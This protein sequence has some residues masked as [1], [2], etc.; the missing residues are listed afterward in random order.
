MSLPNKRNGCNV[1]RAIPTRGPATANWPQ[2]K[3]SAGRSFPTAIP[4][5]AHGADAARESDRIEETARD[6]V[7]GETRLAAI[8]P[9]GAL[10]ETQYHSPHKRDVL[11]V[12]WSNA[13]ASGYL[14]EANG[15]HIIS[16][17]Y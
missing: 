1:R 10:F 14:N 17:R 4:P 2:T 15:D 11:T 6:L 3:Q 7:E 8:G 12:L 9:E 16:V 13:D 5:P